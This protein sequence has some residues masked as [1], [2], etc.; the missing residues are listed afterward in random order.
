MLSNTAD[1]GQSQKQAK[2]SYNYSLQ[3]A[4]KYWPDFE[5]LATTN[6]HRVFARERYP[7]SNHALEQSNFRWLHASAV[8]PGL[9]EGN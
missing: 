8:A 3:H 4:G 6:T 1:L 7:N 5:P 2:S 9:A